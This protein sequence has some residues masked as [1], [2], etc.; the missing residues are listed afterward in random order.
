MNC[1]NG[2][3]FIIIANNR[4]NAIKQ[5]DITHLHWRASLRRPSI[6]NRNNRRTGRGQDAKL[7]SFLLRTNVTKFSKIPHS[8]AHRL[9]SVL[10][11][12]PS[13]CR[14]FVRAVSP[15]SPKKHPILHSVKR[16]QSVGAYR[17]MRQMWH[18]VPDVSFGI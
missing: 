2:S 5:L 10:Y 12:A 13:I 3:N 18:I 11:A 7:S 6:Y 17:R 4:R 9:I 14:D 16:R 15:N 1:D 8:K